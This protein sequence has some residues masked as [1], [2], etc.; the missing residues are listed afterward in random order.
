[1]PRNRVRGSSGDNLEDLGVLRLS[2]DFT[3]LSSLQRR[4]DRK[5]EGQVYLSASPAQLEDETR[6]GGGEE[7]RMLQKAENTCWGLG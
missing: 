5:K 2:S 3:C 6:H 7:G 1:M 4:K